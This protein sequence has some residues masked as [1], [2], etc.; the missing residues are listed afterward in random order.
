[1]VVRRVCEWAKHQANSFLFDNPVLADPVFTTSYFVPQPVLCLVRLV[2]FA[3]CL[4]VLVTNMV[5]NIVH[6]AGWNW[7]AYFTTLTYVGITMYFGFAAYNT[8]RAC[9]LKQLVAREM[10]CRVDVPDSSQAIVAPEIVSVA[11]SRHSSVIY[12]NAQSSTEE[13]L[14]DGEDQV[15]PEPPLLVPLLPAK[16]LTRQLCLATQWLLYESFVCFAPLVTIVY[17]ALLYPM[18]GGFA[19]LDDVWMGVS[20]HAVNTILMALEVLVFARSPMVLGHINFLLTAMTL[21]LGLVYFMVL[22]YG[23]YVYPFFEARYFSGYIAIVCLLVVNIVGI[24]WVAL[25]MV[26]YWRDRAFPKWSAAV[27]GRLWSTS[28][29]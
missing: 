10:V 19:A 26:H 18:S 1:M 12:V 25:F 22:V 8:T 16:K 29:V 4:G 3:Y 11:T 23:F 28:S 17:W 14:T 5:I 6:G 27:R 15:A 21:Y 2:V 13:K 20:M 7:A 24:I 9:V